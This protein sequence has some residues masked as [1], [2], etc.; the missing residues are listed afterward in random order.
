MND[1]AVACSC[2]C[3]WRRSG[4]T[5]AWQWIWP[6]AES[7]S[8]LPN[9][10]AQGEPPSVKCNHVSARSMEI[11][12]R[13]G[14]AQRRPRRRTAGRLSQRRC[15]SHQLSRQ[16][17]VRA[18]KFRAAPSAIRPRTVRIPGGRRRAAAP[19]QPDLPRTDA[20]RPRRDD[21]GL[22]LLNRVEINSFE[23]TPEGVTAQ[24]TQLDSN[25]PI[26]IRA[27]FLVGCDGGRSAVR[28]AIGATLSGTPRFS[29][30]SR[31]ISARPRFSAQEQSEAS[32][33]DVLAQSRPLRQR[34]CHRRP[35]NWLVHIYLKPDEHEFDSV[36]RD[37]ALRKILG[38]GARFRIRDCSARKT[39]SA[40]GWLPT[41]FAKA[42]CSF[43]ATLPICGC[44]WRATA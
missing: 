30:F 1:R 25:Q 2:R 15:L 27:D 12:R 21:A 35:R 36:D 9:L 42:G 3:R 33:G 31:P 13:L 17:T 39:G 19:D 22:T 5:D 8:S 14:V 16:G 20:V 28:R 29:A 34:L 10:R 6:G 4:R 43:A 24:G 38:V 44:R 32:L 26:T 11:F 23:Q 37:W 40:A 7:T 41:S 18:S